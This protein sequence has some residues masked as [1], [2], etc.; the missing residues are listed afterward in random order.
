MDQYSY[1]TMEQSEGYVSA[2]VFSKLMRNVYTWMT[3]ALIMTG[4]TAYL[5]S[6]NYR[7]I[8]V[9]ATNSLLFYGLL[10]G[11]LVLVVWLSA[12]I[13][14]MSALMAALMFAAYAIINGITMSLLFMLY[15]QES[16]A[17]AF[18]ITAGT[19]A[20]M[21]LVGYCIKKD[22]SALGRILI[23]ALIGLIIATVVNIFVASS[24]MAMIL[25]YIGV[26]IFVGLTAYDTQKIK[27]M[28]LEA[29]QY[30]VT[31]E[32]NKYALLGSLTLYLDFINLFLYILRIFGDRR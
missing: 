25:N 11:E 6:H 5:F 10:I 28:M 23:M 3:F 19:F 30:G 18:F 24:A 16:I 27:R 22:L 12:R 2:S 8:E 13:M 15:T 31:D 29:S 20:G 17:Q 21:S 1:D 9:V 4:M 7:L 26:L 32:T 14:K